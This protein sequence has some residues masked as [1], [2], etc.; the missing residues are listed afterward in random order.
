MNVDDSN[1]ELIHKQ[2]LLEAYKRRKRE[3]ELQAAQ[4]GV[5]AD[6]SIKIEIEDIEKQ[7]RL[8][9]QT[10]DPR[11]N[12]LK[13]DDADPL[14][15]FQS[16]GQKSDIRGAHSAK[17]TKLIQFHKPTSFRLWLALIG[18]SVLLAGVGVYILIFQHMGYASDLTPTLMVVSQVNATVNTYVAQGTDLDTSLRWYD[19]K[20]NNLVPSQSP[21][22][23][24][25]I[26]QYLYYSSKLS[27]KEYGWTGLFFWRRFLLPPLNLSGKSELIA[28]IYAE[29]LD[30]LEI[31]F[32][33]FHGNEKKIVL[34]V[35]QGWAGYRIPL[36]E[37]SNV[38]TQK[39]KMLVIAHSQYLAKSNENTFKLALLSFR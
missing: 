24:P 11:S 23:L 13:S 15:T 39:I 6:P 14:A 7:M 25:R 1:Q 29:S 22:N 9:E 21:V 26:N 4:L 34:R 18:V 31:G 17:R 36:E 20:A 30:D 3:R 12:S 19:W 32:A 8:L 35:K 16:V 37:F 28:V 38:D 5:N 33:D 10:I 2:K 27:T